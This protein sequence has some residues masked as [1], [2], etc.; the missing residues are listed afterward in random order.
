MRIISW[1]VNGIRA[2]EKKGFPAWIRDEDA[3]IVCLQETKA[4]PGQL[5]P[6]LLRPADGSGKPYYSYWSSARKKGYSGVAVYSKTE[7]KD[8]Q[9]LGIPEFD[10]EG[11]VL[12]ADF[13]EFVLITAYFPNSQEAGV[14]L[15]YKL[16]FCDA[17]LKLCDSIAAEKR[18]FVLCG[19]YNIA[20]TP[21]DLA[22]PDENEG[23]AGYLPEERAW[24]DR[25]TGAGYIDTFR[26]FHPGEIGHY[27]WWSYRTR[28]RE[29][30][31]GWRIDYH[32]VDPAFLPRVR[33][34]V[35]RPDVAGSDHCPV[36]LE[37]L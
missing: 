19:D 13:G 32:C 9:P 37:L 34:A 36:E 26:H 22:R 31:E 16:A 6:D 3:D 28:A 21:I 25:F 18:H 15:A 27:S 33:R 12:R 20:H 29:R 14:R 7:P 35:I 1:N 4:H 23:S 24:M 5:S 30:N 2:A 11:R 8:V 17:I 10:G